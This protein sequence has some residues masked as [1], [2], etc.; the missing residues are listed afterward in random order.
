MGNLARILQRFGK[1]SNEVTKRGIL[2]NGS[3]VKME[4][5]DRNGE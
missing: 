1:N 5:L 3:Y 4:N 2:P